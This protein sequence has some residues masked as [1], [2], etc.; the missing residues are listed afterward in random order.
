MCASYIYTHDY[1]APRLLSFT[2]QC[3]SNKRPVTDTDQPPVGLLEL[4]SKFLALSTILFAFIL[5]I[6]H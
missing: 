2:I 4:K 3:S 1:V 5:G 6:N